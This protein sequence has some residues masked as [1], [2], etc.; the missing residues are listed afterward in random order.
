[1]LNVGHWT[2]FVNF[3]RFL[4]LLFFLGRLALSSYGA[5]DGSDGFTDILTGWSCF[6]CCVHRRMYNIHVLSTR[7]LLPRPRSVGATWS[8]TGRSNTLGLLHQNLRR[9]RGFSGPANAGRPWE[10]CL[11]LFPKV[12]ALTCLWDIT[13]GA[14]RGWCLALVHPK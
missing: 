2:H 3:T 14:T 11:N 7:W 13:G 5:G 4:I 8:Y 12:P 9:T 6:L 10:I 1:M